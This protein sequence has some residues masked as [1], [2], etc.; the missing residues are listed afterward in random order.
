MDVVDLFEVPVTVQQHRLDR[1]LHAM[2][3][4]MS[5]A[6]VETAV[7]ELLGSLEFLLRGLDPRPDALSHVDTESSLPILR[8]NRLSASKPLCERGAGEHIVVDA[9]HAFE[10]AQ[11]CRQLTSPMFRGAP[12]PSSVTTTKSRSLPDAV[13]ATEPNRMISIGS[14]ASTTTSRTCDTAFR[15]ARHDTTRLV[16]SAGHGDRTATATPPPNFRGLRQ[17]ASGSTGRKP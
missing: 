10:R 11:R 9:E 15:V 13:C 5:H 7:Q 1:F 17:H 3:R 8:R 12:S 16:E 2:L 6:A 14:S 4:V